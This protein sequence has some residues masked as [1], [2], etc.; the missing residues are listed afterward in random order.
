MA[1]LVDI[2]LHLL[3]LELGPGTRP[4]GPQVD[5]FLHLLDIERDTHVLLSALPSKLLLCGLQRHS[6]G[7]IPL[8]L[9]E[10][11]S[12]LILLVP[13]HALNLLAS[14][15]H[16]Q[17]PYKRLHRGLALAPIGDKLDAFL[18]LFGSFD[19]RVDALLLNVLRCLVAG[20]DVLGPFGQLRPHAL[21]LGS[22]LRRE[23]FPAH[24]GGGSFLHGLVAELLCGLLAAHYGLLTLL[25]LEQV[26]RLIL[27]CNLLFL[28]PP[29][30]ESRRLLLLHEP[31]LVRYLPVLLGTHRVDAS[32]ELGVPLPV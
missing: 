11:L 22:L 7:G 23:V 8:N 19:E 10:K 26:N 28:F 2:L 17:A 25:R 13:L 12:L 27:S 30:C 32:L 16:G 18:F 29:R 4:E 20:Q 24:V 9:L 1:K 5:F 15:P 31:R 14:F 3:N 6:A 21:N